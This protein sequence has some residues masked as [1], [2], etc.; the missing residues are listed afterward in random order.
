MILGKFQTF[1][2]FLD[3]Q[4]SRG[5]KE[6]SN[7]LIVKGK[8]CDVFLLRPY[9]DLFELLTSNLCE[10]FEHRIQTRKSA[11]SDEIVQENMRP[12]QVTIFRH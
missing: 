4:T 2:Y 11:A 10:D 1:I 3:S 12:V 9:P 6:I 5:I 8:T 7:F